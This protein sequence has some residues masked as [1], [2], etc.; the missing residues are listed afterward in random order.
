[1]EVIL[2]RH[3]SVDVPAGTCYGQT[4]VP[5]APTFE[6]EAAV[7]KAALEA[8][9]PVDAVWTSPL[10]RCT[11][12]ADYCGY[13]DARRDERLL[14]MNFGEWERQRY[15]EIRDPYIEKWYADYLHTPVPGGE[16]FEMQ[17][18]RVSAFLDELRRQP[19]NRVAV[20]AHG[21]VLVCAGVYAGLAKPEDAF[22]SLTP[23]GGL[24]K[25]TI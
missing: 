4:D 25:I 10:S 3:T 5:L 22:G 12:L 19:Y 14:E 23:Y 1:M 8:C 15:E 20:F 17:F 6:A 11:R 24:R 7:T 13:P 21:G 18:I 16:S 2:I 9:G